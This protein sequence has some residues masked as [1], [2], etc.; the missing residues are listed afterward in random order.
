MKKVQ[1]IGFAVGLALLT[2]CVL[3]PETS[4]S[5]YRWSA[6]VKPRNTASYTIDIQVQFIS[7]ITQGQNRLMVELRQGEPG[8]SSVFDTK[9]FEGQMATVSFLN[10]PEGSYFV[11]IGNGDTVAVGPVR[12][13]SD[14]QR[15]HTNMRV[16]YSSGNVGTRSRSSL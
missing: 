1:N 14:G 5:A 8:A 13:F 4:Q 16:T 15:V 2:G 9:Y 6:T 10:M 11:A 7:E 3:P 12:Q